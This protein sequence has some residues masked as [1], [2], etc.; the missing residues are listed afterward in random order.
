MKCRER[1]V[2]ENKTK[3]RQKYLTLQVNAEQYVFE[4]GMDDQPATGREDTRGRSGR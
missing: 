3:G 4:D 2:W 1:I